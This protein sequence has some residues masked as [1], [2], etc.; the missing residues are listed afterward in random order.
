MCTAPAKAQAITH[1]PVITAAMVL[2]AFRRIPVPKATSI[3]QPAGKTLVNF[4]T[5]FH[6]R[7]DAFTRTVTLLGQRVRLDIKPSR[8][9]WT[10]G[11]G[12]TAVTTTP[13]AAYPAKTIVHRYPHAHATMTHHVT[14]QWSATY[15]INGSAPMDVPGTVTTDGPATDL[16][17]A[18]AIPALS[19]HGH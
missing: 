15:S 11:D 14:V 9:T 13:G 6:T 17:V 7:A 2:A 12:S 10:Y 4:D 8:F 16:R 5:I 18:E 3:T 19:G 1:R